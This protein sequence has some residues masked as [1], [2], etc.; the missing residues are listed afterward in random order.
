MSWAEQ[1]FPDVTMLPNRIPVLGIVNA[2]LERERIIRGNSDLGLGDIYYGRTFEPLEVGAASFFASYPLTIDYLT[3]NRAFNHIAPNGT[4]SGSP[5]WSKVDMIA[6][7]EAR[8]ESPCLID[9]LTKANHQMLSNWPT[10]AAKQSYIGLNLMKYLPISMIMTVG[11]STGSGSSLEEAHSNAIASFPEQTFIIDEDYDGYRVMPFT[12]SYYKQY[13]GPY[14]CYID[15]P[16]S[17]IPDYI[18]RPELVGLPAKLYFVAIPPDTSMVYDATFDA[19]GMGVVNY[20]SNSFQSISLPY[21]LSD[22]PMHESPALA[23]MRF[24][25][26]ALLTGSFIQ[27]HPYCG[28]DCSSL[29]EFYENVDEIPD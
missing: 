5:Y 13:L 22:I 15:W 20:G 4:L 14:W 1:G 9:Q 11:T 23:N 6:A 19:H 27:G 28:V 10:I 16:V 29:F 18:S 7:I 21:Q 25:F 2:R 3:N 8:S 12:T 26:R 24:G 17:I